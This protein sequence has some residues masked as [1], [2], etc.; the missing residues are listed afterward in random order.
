M[1]YA[2]QQQAAVIVVHANQDFLGN[3][4]MKSKVT[5]YMNAN[6]KASAHYDTEYASYLFLCLICEISVVCLSDFCLLY[7]QSDFQYLKSERTIKLLQASRVI[8][9]NVCQH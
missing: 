7:L 3:T 6:L 1:G 9:S 8:G 2:V 5:M 4:V